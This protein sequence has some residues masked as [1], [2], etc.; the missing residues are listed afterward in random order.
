MHVLADQ[1]QRERH[2][3]VQLVLLLKAVPTSHHTP[4]LDEYWMNSEGRLPQ[5][6]KNALSIFKMLESAARLAQNAKIAKCKNTLMSRV[7]HR[8]QAEYATDSDA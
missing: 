1:R 7:H 8:K 6:F 4:P 2:R 5:H 3:D